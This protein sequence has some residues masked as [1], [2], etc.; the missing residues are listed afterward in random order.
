MTEGRKI[1]GVAAIAAGLGA[2]GAVLGMALS[3]PM[4]MGDRAAI[5]K[6]VREYI[7]SHPE[8]LPEAMEN[9]R[10]RE[11]G[12]TVA[13]NRAAIET[14]VGDAWEGAADADV[15]LVEFFD[16]NCGYCKAAIADVDR[17]LAEDKK[18][19]VVYR[20]MPVLGEGSVE[21][22]RLSVAAAMAGKFRQMH[23]PLYAAGHPTPQGLEALRR[24]L[25]LDPK[26]LTS[27][28]VEAALAQ[29]LQL[30]RQLDLSGTPAWVVGDKVLVGAVGYDALKAAI[31]EV[32]A[33]RTAQ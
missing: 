19:K 12:K 33:S 28:Q 15:V 7:L 20:D 30:Q 21:A 8:I 14:P 31:A 23:K 6:I 17:L 32:R 29:N 1:M 5:E 16:Y 2:A 26:A 22:A 11:Q 9:L 10:A 27:P 4:G 25:A 24:K 18:L 3:G 13:V